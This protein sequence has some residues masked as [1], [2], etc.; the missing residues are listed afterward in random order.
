MIR[1]FICVNEKLV[2]M[3]KKKLNASF[4]CG[5]AGEEPIKQQKSVAK[6]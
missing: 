3:V 5:C 4:A 6:F 2:L 1:L